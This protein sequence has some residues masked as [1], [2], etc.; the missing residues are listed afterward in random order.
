MQRRI[1]VPRAD[2][3][4]AGKPEEIESRLQNLRQLIDL[5]AEVHRLRKRISALENGAP[6]YRMGSKQIARIT[7][8]SSGWAQVVCEPKE[9]AATSR[10]R[11]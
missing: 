5:C 6:L 7:N 3:P 9:K 1:S 11:T 10:D 2:I 8:P 4:E